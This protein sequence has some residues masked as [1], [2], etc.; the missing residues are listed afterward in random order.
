[1]LIPLPAYCSPRIIFCSPSLTMDMHHPTQAAAGS[2]GGPEAGK[3]AGSKAVRAPKVSESGG[4]Y[5]VYM[6]LPL[7]T[8]CNPRIMYAPQASIDHSTH[9]ILTNHPTQ[10]AAGTG[11]GPEA[12]K[13]AGPPAPK[14]QVTQGA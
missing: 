1:M 14:A 11:G 3:A 13:A 10:A 2:G 7:P 12:G 6:L 9:H 8:Y 5:F 4:T